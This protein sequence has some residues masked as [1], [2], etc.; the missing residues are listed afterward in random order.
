MTNPTGVSSRHETRCAAP[1]CTEPVT[2]TGRGRP[3]LYHSPACRAAAY[4]ATRH[5]RGAPLTVE[6][7]HGST[8]AKNRPTGRVWLV[9]LRRGD[10]AVIVAAGL[11][12]PSADH[13]AHQINQL[14]HPTPL[15]KGDAIE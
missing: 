14:L 13:L 1:G 9:R 4:R 6:V 7:D 3:A 5:D 10:R 15:A 2:Q 12:R 8:S 11:G